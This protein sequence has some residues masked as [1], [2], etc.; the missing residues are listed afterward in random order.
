MMELLIRRLVCMLMACL[1]IGAYSGAAQAQN[2]PVLREQIKVFNEL[3]T[4]GDL[5]ENAGDASSAP[6]FRAPELGTNGVVAAKRIAAAASQHGLEWLNPGGIG[7]VTVQRPGRLISLDDIRDLIGKHAG[8]NDEAW[9]VVL[10]RGAKSFHIDPRVKA[11]ITIKYIDLQSRTG[12]FR[13]VIS[14]DSDEQAV[15]D[16]T[17]TGL[18]YASVEAIVPSRTIERGATIVEDDLKIVRMA[19]SRVA[20]AAIEDMEAAIGMA[21][22][23]RLI[24]GRPVR[25]TDIEHP[26]LVKRNEMVTIIYKVPGMVL[27]SKGKALADASRGQMV[28]IINLRSKR[29]LEGQVTGTGRVTVSMETASARPKPPKRIA[30]KAA[31]SRGG[32]NSFV[33]R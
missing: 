1:V 33:I 12:K 6:V 19:R 4:L 13:A 16:K 23:H 2:Q 22:K 14:V 29:T 8:G 7:K 11:P 26:K 21:A 15:Q 5:F 9:S 18:A 24:M 17:F 27:K 3:V 25:R 31:N 28:S 10:S 32:R 20:N 30:S